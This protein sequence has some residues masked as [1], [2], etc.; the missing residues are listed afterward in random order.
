MP[1]NLLSPIPLTL[2]PWQTTSW[3]I[4]E[5]HF[6]LIGKII[7]EWS[8]ITQTLEQTI[9]AYLGV[10][11][12]KGRIITEPLDAIRKVN[13]FRSLAETHMERESFKEMKQVLQR[14]L[15]LYSLRS[16]VAHGNWVIIKPDNEVSVM[17]LRNKLPDGAPHDKA[18][19]TLMP[20]E[21][22]EYLISRMVE[23]SNLFIA[24][25]QEILSSSPKT[26]TAPPPLEK[27]TRRKL[28]AIFRLMRSHPHRPSLL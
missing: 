21:Y 23:I 25:R 9:W 18:I 16:L 26:P 10:D 4:P 19:D 15:E 17:S 7:V 24:L 1:R 20:A 22:M 3:D 5:S 14:I 12:S 11:V 13:L 27:Q 2:E 28:P 6:N 8:R